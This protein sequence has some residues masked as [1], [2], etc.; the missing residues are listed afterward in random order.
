MLMSST[1]SRASLPS[2][3]ATAPWAVRPWKV[4]LRAARGVVLH[5]ARRAQ[6]V[7]DMD[8]ERGVHV[9]EVAGP[10][11]ERPADQLLFRRAER[12]HDGAGNVVALHRALERISGAD[13]DAAM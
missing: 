6:A 12:Q 10:H 11:E 1:A 7:P 8:E 4:N 2:Q 9:L 13:R 3:G 5:A